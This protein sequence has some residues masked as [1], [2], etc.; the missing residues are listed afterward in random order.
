MTALLLAVV[1][2]TV[3]VGVLGFSAWALKVYA[4]STLEPKA[5][6]T[7]KLVY[8][9]GRSVIWFVALVAA[10]AVL[11]VTAAAIARVVGGP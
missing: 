10:G 6:L 3:A 7:S 8:Y 2:S 4:S 9:Y 11:G 5:D 1:S